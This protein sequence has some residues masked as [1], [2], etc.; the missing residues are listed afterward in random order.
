[1]RSLT[2]HVQGQRMSV[3]S[4]FLLISRGRAHAHEKFAIAFALLY[5][6]AIVEISFVNKEQALKIA[7]AFYDHC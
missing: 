1:M 6:H 3:S 2:L 5:L 7:L 4:I